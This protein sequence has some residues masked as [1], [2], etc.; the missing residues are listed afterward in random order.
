MKKLY[1][2]I[3]FV[4]LLSC[5][6][7]ILSSSTFS[8][9][10]D[11]LYILNP[12]EFIAEEMFNKRIVMLGE[13]IKHNDLFTFYC[14]LDILNKWIDKA[15]I[16]DTSEINLV[17]IFETTSDA[18]EVLKQYIFTG[19]IKPLLNL[20]APS[21][22]Y[23]TLEFYYELR[24][25]KQRLDSINLDRQYKINIDIQG[26]EEIGYNK[27][28]NEKYYSMN[29]REQE[30][31]FI[32]ERDKYISEG[33]IKYLN[34][35][36]DYNAL[37]LYGNFHLFRGYFNKRSPGLI[38]PDEECMG[39]C[40]VQYLED[41]FGEQNCV[42]I[43]LM[44]FTPDRYKEPRFEKYTNESFIYKKAYEKWKWI[45]KTK[46]NHVLILPYESIPL[47]PLYFIL[48]RFIIEKSIE[49]LKEFEPF[50]SGYKTSSFTSP[51]RFYLS[52]M[53][54]KGLYTS[55]LI[56][57][58]YQKEFNGFEYLDTE[59][60]KGNIF[61]YYLKTY[62]GT[63]DKILRE[64]GFISK[65]TEDS[66]TS[67]KWFEENWI[68]ALENIKIVNAIGIYWVGYPDEKEVAKGYLKSISGKDFDEAAQY[69]Q[70]WRREYMKY[71]I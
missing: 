32:N 50:H 58:W 56:N 62:K 59:E 4:I 47:H 9:D 41:S 21:F 2:L 38:I 19:D 14:F 68:S 60:F 37:I 16:E 5:F 49:K 28:V 29:Q 12:E 69:F 55:K 57:E 15:A 44:G 8:Q 42:T 54:G 35:N 10:E 65:M 51:P 13:G 46:I 25:V 6:L 70:W 1:V 36:P 17:M 67:R 31:W 3:T 39:Y 23:E 11:S 18:A 64:I 34:E 27:E 24:I 53:T 7:F 66:F 45:D 63:A 40:L 48:S 71:G 61:T 30:L 20:V 26:F 33:V 22:Y 43:T 52:T